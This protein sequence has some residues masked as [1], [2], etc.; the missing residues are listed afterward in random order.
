MQENLFAELRA[1]VVAALTE[2][3]PDLPPEIAW[4]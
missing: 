3:V 4:K 1:H 2:I